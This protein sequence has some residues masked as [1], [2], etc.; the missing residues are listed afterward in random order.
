MG[1]PINQTPVRLTGTN[2]DVIIKWI[3]S[4]ARS[5]TERQP[6]YRREFLNYHHVAIDG[7]LIRFSLFSANVGLTFAPHTKLFQQEKHK[8]V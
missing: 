5:I 1:S 6:T 7:S 8:P 3:N 4:T 2:L